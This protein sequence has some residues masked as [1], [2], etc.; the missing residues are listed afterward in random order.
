MRGVVDPRE[1]GPHAPVQLEQYQRR[2]VAQA[3][4]R[5]GRAE[6]AKLLGSLGFVAP[7]QLLGT[8]LPKGA[9]SDDLLDACIACWTATRIAS[10]SATVG[11]AAPPLDARGLRMELWR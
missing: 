7:L 4:R 6:R 11:P 8:K 3:S 2:E 10:G 1:H 9:K 5:A